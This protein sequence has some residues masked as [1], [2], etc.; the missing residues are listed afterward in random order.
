MT[1]T[2]TALAQLAAIILVV[3][4]GVT[5]LLKT[6]GGNGGK[7]RAALPPG[8]KGL[9]LVG[10]IRD[11]PPPGTREWEHWAKHRS[12][13]GPISSVTVFGTTIIVLNDA[14]AAFELLEKRG[15]VH[16]SR[17]RMVFL[18]DLCGWRDAA[19]SLPYGARLRAYRQRFHRFVGTRAAFLGSG[20]GRYASLLEVEARRFLLRAL[21]QP[22]ALLQHARTEAGAIILQMAYGYTVDPRGGGARDPLVAGADRALAQFSVAAVPG[23]WLVDML[24]VLR[25]MPSWVPGAGFQRTARFFRDTIMETAQKPMEFVEHQMAAGMYQPSYVSEEIERAG[26]LDKITEDDRH[27][28]KWSAA[29][30]YTGGADTS[31]S[32]MQTFF[33]AMLVYPEVQRKA[34]EEIDRVVGIQRLPTLEDRSKLP[35]VDAVVSESLRWHPVA[36]MGLPHVPIQDDIYEGYLI[37]KDAII[38]PNIWF[39]THDPEVYTDPLVFDPERYLVDSPPPDPRDYVFGFGRRI[40]P[41]RLLADSSVWL[42]IA[43]SLSALEFRKPVVN[44]KELEPSVLFEPGGISHPYPFE[45]SIKPRSPGHEQLIRAIENE[46]PWGKGSAESAQGI[47]T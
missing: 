15:S 31:V 36:P 17:P 4:Y 21:E 6:R 22:D 32:T 1:T 11:L 27:V 41:G 25:H 9:P 19:A 12:L 5:L 40:C 16:S 2:L 37:P 23:A 35:Y 45:A 33:L 38:M 42:T 26:G 34:Q 13:Y 18:M 29:S 24:P 30:L 8:P 39:F 20:G 14:R 46:H 47:W 44:G 10:N 7:V 28:T 43:K 3:Y